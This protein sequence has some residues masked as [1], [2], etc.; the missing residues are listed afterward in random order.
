MQAY[1]DKA[2]N[3]SHRYR[4]FYI[5]YISEADMAIS[6]A[7]S[8]YFQAWQ[9]D[10]EAIGDSADVLD[11]AEGLTFYGN[12][13]TGGSAEDW[14]TLFGDF[15]E[16]SHLVEKGL[17]YYDKQLK[18]YIVTDIDALKKYN[19]N[20]QSIETLEAMKA[21]DLLANYKDIQDKYSS[22]LEGTL[23]NMDA[24]NLKK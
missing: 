23:S 2:D 1:I 15:T 10:I 24:I 20:L 11:A 9:K 18:Q 4:D 17:M 3:S 14:G 8:L 21:D 5:K 16:V 7:N 19:T 12:G 22:A 13:V 6:D